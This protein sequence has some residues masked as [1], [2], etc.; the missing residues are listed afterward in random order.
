L[1][2]YR[3]AY[4]EER[5]VE[6]GDGEACRGELDECG[7]RSGLRRAAGGGSQHRAAAGDG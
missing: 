7:G 1:C 3:T 4:A 6:A 5:A 2:A